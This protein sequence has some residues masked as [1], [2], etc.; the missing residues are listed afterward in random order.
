ML[1]LGVFGSY[2]RGEAN[3]ASDLDLM[4][5]LSRHQLSMSS[6]AWNAISVSKWASR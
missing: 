3:Q 2:V 5:E 4:V 6:Y 1:Y